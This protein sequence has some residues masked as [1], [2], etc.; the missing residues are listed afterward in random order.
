MK[1]LAFALVGLFW[2]ISSVP[3]ADAVVACAAGYYW[4]GGRCVAV[5]RRPAAAAPA[6]QCYMRAGVRVCR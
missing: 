4:S 1:Y 2:L 6:T 5:V 3:E